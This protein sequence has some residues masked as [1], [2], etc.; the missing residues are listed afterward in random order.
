MIRARARQ[1]T[2]LGVAP[3][4]PI[5]LHVWQEGRSSA[6][7]YHRSPLQAKAPTPSKALPAVYVVLFLAVCTSLAAYRFCAV[8]KKAMSRLEAQ[9]LAQKKER[10]KTQKVTISQKR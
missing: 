8:G 4:L 10:E 9:E 5:S 7:Q 1:Y 2:P 6:L 3:F